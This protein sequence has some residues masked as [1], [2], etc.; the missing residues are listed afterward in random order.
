MQDAIAEFLRAPLWAQV[1]MTAFVLVIAA[2]AAGSYVTRRRFRGRF[3]AIAQ[4]LGARAVP[5]RGAPASFQ[6]SVN[7]RLFEVRYEHINNA[8]QESHR[9]PEGHLLFTST[10]LDEPGRP[11]QVEI[12]VAGALVSRLSASLQATGDR[13]FDARFVVREDGPPVRD[14]WCDAE[15]RQR[16]VELYDGIAPDS[17]LAIGDRRLLVT[18]R[19]PWTGIDG[20]AL[21]SLL[22]RQAALA[23]ALER[24][25][26][27]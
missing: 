9:G 22:E 19:E 25:P 1:A 24:S 3:T 20:T 13:D 17:R 21:R 16:I 5:S 4:A 6:S 18:L 15:V 23:M 10:R 7:G 11:H 26:S 8:R 27:R 12:T 2:S 14:G